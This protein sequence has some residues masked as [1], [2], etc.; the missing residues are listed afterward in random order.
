MAC[1]L[2]THDPM[3]LSNNTV[4]KRSSP[5]GLSHEVVLVPSYSVI[6]GEIFFKCSLVT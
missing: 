6:Y 3:A 5:F 4:A 1:E 2:F